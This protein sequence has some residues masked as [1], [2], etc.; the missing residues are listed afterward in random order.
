MLMA[1]RNLYWNVAAAEPLN[2]PRRTF[3]RIERNWSKRYGINFN[4]SDT[5]ITAS[6]HSAQSDFIW[7]DWFNSLWFVSSIT[8]V[9]RMSTVLRITWQIFYSI[10]LNCQLLALS[11]RS[12][13]FEVERRKVK[14]STVGVQ[15]TERENLIWKWNMMVA[16]LNEIGWYCDVTTGWNNG[17]IDSGC[18]KP[19]TTLPFGC[20]RLA[21]DEWM[22]FSFHLSLRF[23]DYF[24]FVFFSLLFFPF[25][26]SRSTQWPTIY[27]TFTRPLFLLFRL[28][29][30][31]VCCLWF[32]LCFDGLVQVAYFKLQFDLWLISLASPT[33]SCNSGSPRKSNRFDAADY[34][35]MN[36]FS[37]INILLAWINTFQ[38]IS[39]WSSP[40]CIRILRS[41]LQ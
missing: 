22:P 11:R 2:I 21:M 12:M 35:L 10:G 17:R 27:Y 19:N 15:P 33:E 36:W 29:V 14:R 23:Y 6:I 40:D 18:R 16:S 1:F 7:L 4:K 38:L 25:F 8:T 20:C 37:W 9:D 26:T 28:I 41:Q 5:E 31:I 34:G 32:L 30:T 3:N 24:Q 13:W 39:T